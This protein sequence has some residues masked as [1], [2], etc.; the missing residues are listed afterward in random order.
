MKP[1]PTRAQEAAADRRSQREAVKDLIGRYPDLKARV[2]AAFTV[3]PM[4][5]ASYDQWSGYIPLDT[6]NAGG[7][8]RPNNSP[9]RIA[10]AEILD[11]ARHR[12]AAENHGEVPL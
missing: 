6:Y 9:I 8:E 2:V 3:G 12:Y 7:V 11:E 5:M 10:L 1:P 4:T